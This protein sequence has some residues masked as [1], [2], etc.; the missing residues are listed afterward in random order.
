M[1][2]ITTK[3]CPHCGNRNLVLIRTQSVKICSDCNTTI[4]WLLDPGQKPIP[5]GAR[6][7]PRLSQV[8]LNAW[9][10]TGAIDT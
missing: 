3:Q 10:G 7:K 9:Y 5:E 6:P 8:A 2:K 1:S 4:P